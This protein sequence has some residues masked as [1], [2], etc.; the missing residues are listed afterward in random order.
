MKFR[1]DRDSLGKIKIP[2]GAYYGAFTGRAIQQYHVTGNRAHKNLI[3]AF[4]M[5]KRQRRW[6][7][8]RQGQSMQS[9][10][11]P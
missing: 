11:T 9:A 5:I 6:P 1:L 7:T 4:V 3:R 8:W 2:A 10:E